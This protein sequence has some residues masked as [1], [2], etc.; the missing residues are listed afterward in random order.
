MFGRAYGAA[1]QQNKVFMVP[2]GSLLTNLSHQRSHNPSRNE[3]TASSGL[4]PA[5]CR[6]CGLGIAYHAGN[7]HVFTRLLPLD[8]K[9]DFLSFLPP[10][11]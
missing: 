5:Y 9:I 10:Q 11:Q 4:R 6:F 7:S 8:K 2:N 1:S 3:R